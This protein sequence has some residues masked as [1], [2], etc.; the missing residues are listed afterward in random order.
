MLA[1]EHVARSVKVP[2]TPTQD[3]VSVLARTHVAAKYKTAN[4]IFGLGDSKISNCLNFGNSKKFSA[5]PEG[6]EI[7][8]RE[9]ERDVDYF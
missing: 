9:R 1:S 6:W 4:L 5:S 8:Q 2:V 3:E 7:L